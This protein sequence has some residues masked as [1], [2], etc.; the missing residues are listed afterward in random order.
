MREKHKFETS[1][2]SKV[3]VG[4]VRYYV[5]SI[6]WISLCM[7]SFSRGLGTHNE[8]VRDTQPIPMC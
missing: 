4:T 1:S 2:E 7:H 8:P 5:L 3:P 6:S